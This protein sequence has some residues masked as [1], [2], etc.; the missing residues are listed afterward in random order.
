VPWQRSRIRS[1]PEV[2]QVEQHV[3]VDAAALVDL[4]LLGA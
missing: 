3:A 2:A 1:A 4:R